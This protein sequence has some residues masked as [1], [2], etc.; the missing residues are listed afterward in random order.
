MFGLLAF[1]VTSAAVIIG[2]IQAK[3]FVQRK[4]RYVD[5]AQAPLA[6]VIAGIGAAIIA[7]PVVALLPIVGGGTALMF[8]AAVGAGVAAGAREIRRKLPPSF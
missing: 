6:P 8:G 2:F 5:A 1:A 3:L 7:S 4:L